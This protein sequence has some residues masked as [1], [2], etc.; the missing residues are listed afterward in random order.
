LALKWI[1]GQQLN[2][3]KDG[4]LVPIQDQ[5]S[6]PFNLVPDQHNV[7]PDRIR[8]DFNHNI[9]TTLGAVPKGECNCSLQV[10]SFSKAATAKPLPDVPPAERVGI[11]VNFLKD[12]DAE[13]ANIGSPPTPSNELM[14]PQQVNL[15]EF[16]LGRSKPLAEQ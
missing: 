2:V 4:H 15:H 5:I 13:A 11:K 10:E 3:N 16:G 12:F 9:G 6:N 14:M 7:A 8:A 1:C